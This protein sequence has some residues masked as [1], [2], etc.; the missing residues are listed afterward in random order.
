MKA[1]QIRWER[2]CA[3]VTPRRRPLSFWLIW[4]TIVWRYLS[5]GA[6]YCWQHDDYIQY[7]NYPSVEDYGLLLKSEGLLSSRPLAAIFDLWFWSKFAGAMMVGVL[8]LAMLYAAS[9]MLWQS[10][11]HRRFGT[12]WIFT[13]IYTLLP[14]GFEGTYWMSA[15]T[16]LICGL[17]FGGLA[18][19]LLVRF[20]E[21]RCR[22]AGWLYFPVLLLSYGHYEQTLVLSMA[23]SLLLMLDY[24]PARRWK[25]LL[26][27]LTF[28]AAACYFAFTSAFSG[29]GA[30]SSRME[31]AIPD[32]PYYFKVFLPEISGQI[33]DAFLG[34]GFGTTV[35]GFWRGI[36]LIAEEG[37]W[38]WLLVCIGLT[39]LYFLLVR[40]E[41][42]AEAADIPPTRRRVLRA[43]WGY[44]FG[45]LLALAPVSIFFFIA[46]PWFSIRNTLPSFIGLAFMVD[47][48]VRLCLRR[49]VRVRAGI[50]AALV[51]I[52]CIGSVSEMHDYRATYDHDVVLLDRV[53]EK[54]TIE[55]ENV[56]DGKLGILGA[57]ATYLPDQNYYFNGHITAITSSDW[58]LS[59]ALTAKMR[60]PLRQS[61]VPL[62]TNES[63]LYRGW[64]RALRQID[65]FAVLW[66]WDEPT[67]TLRDLRA[68]PGEDGRTRLYYADDGSFCAVVW[69]ELASNGEWFGYLRFTEQ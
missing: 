42:S 57:N 1:L 60:A 59:G 5:C 33:R 63:F 36:L 18:L 34:G 47:L 67:K 8:L 9:A 39:A 45:F 61:I 53:I 28:P 69:E 64:S 22:L 51:L 65:S 38:L 44:L 35:R 55:G 27:L 4:G 7:I 37:K 31:L 14:L 29:G 43:L 62:P 23:A 56:P 2:F 66:Y 68:V 6:V 54:L 52:F 3:W 17:F 19:W 50:C 24:L 40:R 26:A 10:V 30:L 48:T 32:N 58:E 25:S 12:G 20:V 15:G 11:L 13:A 46:N 21:D 16:R 49:Q 41:D